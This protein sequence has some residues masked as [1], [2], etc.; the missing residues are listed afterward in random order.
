MPIQQPN[1]PRTILIGLPAYN[2]EVA[3]GRLLEK[4]RQFANESGQDVKV[5]VYNDGCVDRTPDIALSWQDRL[6]LTLL[7][8]PTNRGLGVGLGRLVEYATTT[9]KERD[10]FVLM[11]CDDTHHP[12]QIAEMVQAID[13]GNDIVIASRFRRG[14][15]VKGVPLYRQALTLAAILLFKSIYPLRG[16]N[17]YTCGYRCYRVTLLCRAWGEF[18]PALVRNAGFSCMVELLLK[19]ALY[20][21]KFK[22]IPLSLRYDLKPTAS[23]MAVGSNIRRLIMLLLVWRFRGIRNC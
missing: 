15:K 21:P 23:K 18:G 17:D 20:R 9:A 6:D 8:E 3:I 7:G 13:A 12:G 22:E 5:V 11:D 16:V 4:I 1:D 10:L 2:E 14:A 19:L